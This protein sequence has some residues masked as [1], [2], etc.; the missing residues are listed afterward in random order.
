MINLIHQGG[1]N[2]QFV[3][4][5]HSSY[6]S[7]KFA[8]RTAV[9]VLLN[10]INQRKSKFYL[11]NAV[12]FTNG[13]W[14]IFPYLEKKELWTDKFQFKISFVPSDLTLESNYLLFFISKTFVRNARLKLAKN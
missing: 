13:K 3:T 14:K 8:K 10:L 6:S 9:K 1:S 2:Y 5:V 7:S 12:S 4:H 11:L